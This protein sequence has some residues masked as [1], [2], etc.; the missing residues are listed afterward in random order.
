MQKT[1]T[2]DMAVESH[3]NVEEHDVGMA[4]P[5]SR[6]LALTGIIR[7]LGYHGCPCV[8]PPSAVTNLSEIADRSVR[9]TRAIRLRGENAVMGPRVRMEVSNK[10]PRVTW[11]WNPTLTSKST[12]LGW[13][14]R[15]LVAHSTEAY[16]RYAEHALGCV[17]QIV[18]I[19]DLHFGNH[20][21]GLV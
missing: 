16:S 6:S 4:Q 14:T 3:P 7:F 9:A 8:L 10:G 20:N 19:S 17:M 21:D 5:A 1:P 13:A 2:R 15:P 18:Q 11:R 12:T